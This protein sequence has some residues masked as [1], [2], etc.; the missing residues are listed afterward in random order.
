MYD[1]YVETDTLELVAVIK[2]DSL[3]KAKEKALKMGYGKGYRIE[4][5]W[6]D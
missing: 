1:V 2:A 5:S 3:E 4:E 6:E